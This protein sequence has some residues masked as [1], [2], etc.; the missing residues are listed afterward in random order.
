MDKEKRLSHLKE[1]AERFAMT[2]VLDMAERVLSNHE[3]LVTDFLDPHFLSLAKNILHG[4]PQLDYE[5]FGGHTGAERQRILLCPDYYQPVLK[6]FNLACVKVEGKK[7]FEVLYHKDFL[8]AILGLG[9]RREKVGD[10]IVGEK[11]AFCFMTDEIADYVSGHL[12]K[13][14]QVGVSISLVTNLND[15]DSNSI[16]YKQI[17]ATVASLRLDSVGSHGFRVSRN[18]IVADIK[19]GKVKLNWKEVLN[20]SKDISAGDMISYRGHGRVLVHEI[21]GE[22]KKGRIAI[23]L[24]LIN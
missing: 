17:R 7:G 6:D 21:Q 10:I 9:L 8:G 16:E 15:V 11:A 18:Q 4:L 2:R 5:L 1:A 22:T 12:D 3:V 20:P 14:G 23:L 13:V 19:A 24:N